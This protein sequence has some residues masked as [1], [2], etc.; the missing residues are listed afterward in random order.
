MVTNNYGLGQ[1]GDK[2]GRL[3]S[4]IS[5]SFLSLSLSLIRERGLKRKRGT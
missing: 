1:G 5:F 4:G 3:D 2:I